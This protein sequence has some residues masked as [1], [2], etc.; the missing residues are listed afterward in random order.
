MTLED[1]LV[2]QEELVLAVGR[3]LGL[4]YNDN[5]V[6][7]S[8]DPEWLQDTL[9]TLISLFRRYRLVALSQSPSTWH[10]I[11]EHSGTGC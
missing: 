1:Q 10:V 2:A 9:N 6:V 8:R 11:R 7:V 5:G 3:C 4:F